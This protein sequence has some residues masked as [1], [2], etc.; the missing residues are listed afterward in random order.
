MDSQFLQNV[1]QLATVDIRS[2]PNYKTM[3]AIANHPKAT[4]P[5]PDETAFGMEVN[6]NQDFVD[7]KDFQRVVDAYVTTLNRIFDQLK[8]D[9]PFPVAVRIFEKMGTK[10]S[11]KYSY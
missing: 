4:F 7:D 5:H 3:L 8:S 10:L 6:V 11:L 1:E 2:T 9:H